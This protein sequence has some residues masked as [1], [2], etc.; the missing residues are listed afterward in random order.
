MVEANYCKLNVK[1]FPTAKLRKTYVVRSDLCLETHVVGNVVLYERWQ[2]PPLA[3]ARGTE[4]NA[5][6]TQKCSFLPSCP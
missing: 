3:D 4:T 2:L 1:V 6:W 5:H